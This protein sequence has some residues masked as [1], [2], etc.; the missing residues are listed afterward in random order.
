MKAD[1]SPKSLA[2]LKEF[3]QPQAADALVF[4]QGQY[5]PKPQLSRRILIYARKPRRLIPLFD[6][7]V[8]PEIVEDPG[9]RSSYNFLVGRCD[10]MYATT[11]HNLWFAD[12][13]EFQLY[14]PESGGAPG[15]LALQERI[16]RSEREKYHAVHCWVSDDWVDRGVRLEGPKTRREIAQISEPIAMI[17]PTYDSLDLSMDAAWVTDLGK[18][19]ADFLRIE[20]KSHPDLR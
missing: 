11:V 6:G 4:C 1:E 13:N 12:R 7:W 15:E 8:V 3:L 14:G 18:D 19:L 5:H 16:D 17:D 9:W 10:A 20:L 2:E